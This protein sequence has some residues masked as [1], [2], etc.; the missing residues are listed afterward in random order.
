MSNDIDGALNALR[1][2][3]G[4]DLIMADVRLDISALIERLG[5]ERISIPVV[6][7]GVGNDADA[8]VRAIRAG[9]KEYIP[10]PPDAELIAAVLEAVTEESNA[11]IY[12]DPQMRGDPENS[13]NRWRRPT[14]RS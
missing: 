11:I 3:K 5:S 6:G 14:R 12:R 10:L 8:A 9:A 1:T 7:C 4:A 2:G 13:P